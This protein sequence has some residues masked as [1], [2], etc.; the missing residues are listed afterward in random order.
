[1]ERCGFWGELP[2][3][4]FWF[5]GASVGEIN[6]IVPL[7]L[8]LRERCPEME[9]L[10]TAVSITGL[11]QASTRLDDKAWLHLRLLPFDHSYW[12]SKAIGNRTPVG[13]VF[14]ETELWPELIS[15]LH[16]RAV[17][18]GLVNGRMSARSARRYTIL[19]DIVREGLKQLEV[20]CIQSE[21]ARERLLGLGVRPER[22]VTTGNTKYDSGGSLLSDAQRAQRRAELFPDNRPIV[23]L[24]SLRCGEEEE[25][26]PEM[27]R[28]V[29]Q[30]PGRV[31][32]VVA[33]RHEEKFEYFARSLQDHKLS[34]RRWSTRAKDKTVE[35][36]RG[37]APAVVLLDAM[38][39][40]ADIYSVASLCFIGGTLRDFGGHNPLE[41][42]P[43]GAAIC[44]G[45]YYRN[46]ADAV[47]LLKEH[48]GVTELRGSSDLAAVLEAVV[49]PEK[50]INGQTLTD[51]GARGRAAWES[52]SGALARTMQ[53]L[54]SHGV[55]TNACA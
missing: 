34:F 36:H 11:E 31:G 19:G 8:A 2:K 5:H 30:Y 12:I 17:P 50:M 28:C 51:I 52:Q 14:S 29:A 37:S 13:F 54:E 46:A 35:E 53:A 45:P 38:G 33:P 15:C 1:M 41:P 4:F 55:I 16:R 24:G 40:L 6:G 39:E 47:V 23:V 42:A 49:H 26:F 20:V 21:E 25:W 7:I 43:Y 44:L 3:R 22:A 27:A 9:I 32:F 18:M 48:N 10:V